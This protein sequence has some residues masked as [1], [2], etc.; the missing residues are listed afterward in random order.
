MLTPNIY[1]IVVFFNVFCA[2]QTIML[3]RRISVCSVFLYISTMLKSPPGMLLLLFLIYVSS[4]WKSFFRFLG[5]LGAYIFVIIKD[6]IPFHFLWRDFVP[7][8][9]YFHKMLS[10]Y[11]DC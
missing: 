10:I 8:Y 6:D 7:V 3:C 11:F 9:A 2:F 5:M 4:F 1:H